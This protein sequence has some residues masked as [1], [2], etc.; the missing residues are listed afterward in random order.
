M[1][2]YEEDER[3]KCV[4][5]L[6]V[7]AVLCLGAEM[8][9]AQ[10]PGE[11]VRAPAILVNNSHVNKT[12]D[13]GFIVCE[14]V[15]GDF[16]WLGFNLFMVKVGVEFVQSVIHQQYLSPSLMFPMKYIYPIIPI[17][18]LL[19]AIRMVQFSLKNILHRSGASTNGNR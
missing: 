4:Y 3:M 19:I 11:V 2:G 6:M 7:V 14:G 18:F 5:L 16:I 8:A 15:I 9:L 17:G 13:F 12:I 10:Q 1:L